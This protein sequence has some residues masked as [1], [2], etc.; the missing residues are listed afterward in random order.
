MS[1]AAS[2]FP[3]KPL[4][5]TIRNLRPAKNDM[6]IDLLYIIIQVNSKHYIIKIQY[7]YLIFTNPTLP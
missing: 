6:L 7:N 1:L 4:P 3:T 2:R 5:P